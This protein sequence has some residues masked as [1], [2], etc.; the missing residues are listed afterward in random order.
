MKEVTIDVIGDDLNKIDQITRKVSSIAQELLPNVRHVL[1]RYKPPRE[2]VRVIIDKEKSESLGIRSQD[3]GRLLRYGIQGGV[4][5]KFI[6]EEREVDVRIRYDSNYRDQF[7]DLR[8]YK[9]DTEKGKSV[10]LL[11]IASLTRD[12][13]PV[14]IYRKNKRRVLSFSLRI[15]DMSL[16][17]ILP[18]LEKLKEIE[19]PKQY[20]IEFSDS[21]QKVL[22]H[23][24]K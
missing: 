3:I 12:T 21:L 9:I 19:L 4:A 1:L 17:E 14:R 22:E 24:K 16:T 20:R 7:T 2:E 23:Q 10:P 6:E 15:T 8:E 11:E 13:T 18:K 5:T